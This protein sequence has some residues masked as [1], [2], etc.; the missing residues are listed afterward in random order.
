MDAQGLLGVT[1]KRG[2]A[3]INRGHCPTPADVPTM[4]TWFERL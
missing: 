1:P 3:A 2:P 4:G